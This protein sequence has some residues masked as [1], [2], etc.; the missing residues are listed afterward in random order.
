VN[1]SGA[2]STAVSGLNAST[3]QF[4]VAANNIVNANT[5]NYEVK[6]VRTLSQ[7][8]GLGQGN[9]V[10]GVIATVIDGGDFNL[11]S[12]YINMT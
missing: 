1:V 6:E 10:G 11:A 3:T 2:L 4:R 5:Q 7:A 9:T 12:E 8:A